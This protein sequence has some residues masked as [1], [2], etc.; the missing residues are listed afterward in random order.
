MAEII[1][2]SSLQGL[3]RLTELF[4]ER[5]PSVVN[6][7]GGDWRN[8]DLRQFTR[9]RRLTTERPSGLGRAIRRSYGKDEIPPAVDRSLDALDQTDALAVVTG[10]QL[11]LFGGPLYTY[12]KAL[13]TVLLARELEAE[14][15]GPVIPVFWMESADSDFNEVNRISF[16][17]Q[18]SAP[19]RATYTPRDIVAGKSV[20][21]HHFTDEII[22]PRQEVESWLQDLPHGVVWQDALRGLYQ[23]AASLTS[24][25]RNL[26]TR[27]MG[28]Y[29]LVI[30]DPFHPEL[31]DRMKTFWQLCLERPERLNYTYAVCSSE[32]ETMRL[33]LQVR[34]RDE[35][36]PIYQIN[37]EGLRRRIK[38]DKGNYKFSVTGEDITSE[39]LFSL[40][41]D[42]EGFLAPAVLL[43][44]LYQDF[45]LPTWIQV[46][47]PSEIAYLAQI[48]R[49]YDLLGTPRPLIA[50]RLSLTLVERQVRRL[51]EKHNWTV[52]ET[53]GGRE[54]LM[55]R[56]GRSES[57]K[58]LFD[59]GSQQLEGWRQ[60]IA[61][62]A[63]EASIN[64]AFELDKA[65]QRMNHQWE[66][67][68]NITERKLALR[69]QTRL[70]HAQKL[71]DRLLPEGSLQERQQ[72]VLYYAA[73]FGDRLAQAIETDAEVFAAQHVVIDLE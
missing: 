56:T 19:R 69:D 49:S 41:E 53:L 60:R 43:R 18:D 11:G 45:L 70:E 38:G 1:S 2:W 13:T 33:P 51:L 4:F 54:V 34:L 47:G 48:G 32:I 42:Q 20:R 7:L 27:L 3:P 71:S 28:D 55:R 68:R 9:E 44:P 36:L 66:K 64:L 16:P 37:A 26:M 40:L 46:A 8:Q 65:G 17:S 30:V 29:G 72:N 57:L 22:P 63:E 73:K 12:Y 58:E 39:G 15:N 67:L 35:T 10:Q 21:C 50:P 62:M 14:S 25:F 6:L 61:V 31:R 52:A 23:P 5:R 24:A 59:H